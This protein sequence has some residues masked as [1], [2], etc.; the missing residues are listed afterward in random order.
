M[1]EN[2]IAWFF[3]S[4]LAFM[5]YV[6]KCFKFDGEFDVHK[7]W[8]LNNLNSV[9]FLDRYSR[10]FKRWPTKNTD[11]LPYLLYKLTSFKKIPFYINSWTFKSFIKYLNTFF[12]IL[13]ERFN[14]DETTVNTKNVHSLSLTFYQ[15]SMKIKENK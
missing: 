2:L 11:Y 8:K 13:Y 5:K 9:A 4:L 12:S 3:F 10:Q 7:Q 1:V 14:K 6:N 15:N